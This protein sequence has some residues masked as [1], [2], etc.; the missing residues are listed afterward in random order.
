MCYNGGARTKEQPRFYHKTHEMS[1]FFSKKIY[2]NFVKFS[3]NFVQ[4]AQF[5]VK[6]LCKPAGS[7]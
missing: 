4:I 3:Q 1:N 5:T 6:M 2:K 7:S